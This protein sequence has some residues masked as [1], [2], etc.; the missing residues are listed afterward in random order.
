VALVKCSRKIAGSLSI[1]LKVASRGAS[2]TVILKRFLAPCCPRTIN[3]KRSR[4]LVR[5]SQDASSQTRLW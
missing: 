5:A 2:L 4:N 1:R 3:Y